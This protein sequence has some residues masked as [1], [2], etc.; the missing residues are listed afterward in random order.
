MF[1]AGVWVT[2]P[3][4]APSGP[5]LGARWCILIA[6]R[7]EA[8]RGSAGGNLTFAFQTDCVNRCHT[9]KELCEVPTTV[10]NSDSAKADYF[11]MNPPRLQFM[12]Y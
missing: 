12:E 7:D 3:G 10:I 8:V 5:H 11:Y 4:V 1:H 6:V 9:T 2:L